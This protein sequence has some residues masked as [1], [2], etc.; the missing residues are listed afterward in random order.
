MKGKGKAE[1]VETKVN[2]SVSESKPLSQ[3]DT[4]K[5]CPAYMRGTVYNYFV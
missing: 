5:Q 1:K 2:D 3:V 4:E